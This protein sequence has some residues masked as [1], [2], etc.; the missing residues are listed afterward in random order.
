M[1]NT[2]FNFKK[3]LGVLFSISLLLLISHLVLSFIYPETNPQSISLL[4]D[5][6][7]DKRFKESLSSF[8]IKD[9]WI[10]IVKDKSRIP[11]Y[12]VNVPR[13]L[14]IPQ[15]LG[16]LI[17]QYDGYNI[18]VTA[19]EKRIHGRTLMELTFDN[20]IKL[21]ADFRYTED[22]WRTA[23]RSSLFIYGRE[24]KEAEYDSLM[25]TTTRDISALLI[26]SKS[27]A[28]YSTWL[29]NN[30]FDYA[31]LLNN[32]I[33]D[34]EFRLSKDYSEKRLKLIVQ[35]II[36]S[37]PNALFYAINKSSDIYSSPNYLL[38][39]KE[40]DKRKIRFF[41]TDSLKFIDN[42][43]QNISERLN[44]IV[45]NVK[46]EDITRIAISLE[47]YQTL[48]GEL[49]KLIRIGYKFVKTSELEK[50]EVKSPN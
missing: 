13:D 47:A 29:R 34:L 12:R 22:I 8:A 16:E 42:T 18:E 17:K 36:V 48:T 45:K 15:I 30:G 40:F 10:K 20:E 27:N 31:V 50:K 28:S 41:T 5:E 6:E 43:Q 25:L 35:N 37:F 1:I 24:T 26:P 46:E 14:P 11:S 49:K 4:T 44:S 7:I 9:E 19:E 39:K 38:I 32:E 21:K 33:K 3:L 23:S 2:K